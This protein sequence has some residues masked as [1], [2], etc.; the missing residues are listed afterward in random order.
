[1]RTVKLII[2][3]D[4]SRFF[5]WQEQAGVRTI[6]ADLKKALQTILRSPIEGLTASGRTDKGVHA[7]GQV[8][9]FRTANDSFP[10]DR[11]KLGV[12]ALMRDEVAVLS[13]DEMPARFNARFTPHIK[14]YSYSILTRRAPPILE[15]HTMWHVPW[16]IDLEKMK[17]AARD[18]V[19]KHDFSSFQATDCT[20]DSAVRTVEESQ[21]EI[22][23]DILVYR[24]VARS[25]L[26]QMVRSIVGTLVAL[27]EGRLELQSM[28]EVLEAR[29]RKKAGMTAPARG[30]CLDWVR[31]EE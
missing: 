30:L 4:G 16:K 22:C 10:L 19:G 3:Y 31:Y 17:S 5:G 13:A 2:E 15:R 26:K 23:G 29:D 14:Q 24:V 28:R 9:S 1:M 6:Q 27:G 12:S 18:L 20:A 7:R 11:L 8:V 25:F 21:F